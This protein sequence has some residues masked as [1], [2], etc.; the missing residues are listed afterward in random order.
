MF[1]F[2]RQAPQGNRLSATDIVEQHRHGAITVVDVRDISELKA[3]GTASGSVHAPLMLLQAKADP[4]HPEH[5]K[6]LNPD[7]PIALFCASGARSG[8][9]AGMLQRLGYREVHNIGGFGDWLRA[10]GQVAKV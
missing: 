6:R 8:M 5:D 1:A 2:L 10:G 7:A 3:S 9:A 4:R